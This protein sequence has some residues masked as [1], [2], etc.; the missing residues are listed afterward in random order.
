MLAQ[1]AVCSRPV[2]PAA[3]AQ[4]PVSAA[5][6]RDALQGPLS[7]QV[8]SPLVIFETTQGVAPEHLS[9]DL[10]ATQINT[11]LAVTLCA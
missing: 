8:T 4:C 11:Y 7:K 1:V 10:L 3:V 5:R 6:C 9:P 2:S